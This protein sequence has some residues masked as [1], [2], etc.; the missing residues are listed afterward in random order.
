MAFGQRSGKLEKLRRACLQS[1]TVAVRVLRHDQAYRSQG[2]DRI[3]R[4]AVRAPSSRYISALQVLPGVVAH[5]L[6]N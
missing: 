5:A 1:A 6:G 2:C 4:D 3:A